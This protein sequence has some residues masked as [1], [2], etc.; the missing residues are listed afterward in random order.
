[1][2]TRSTLHTA[3]LGGVVASAGVLAATIVVAGALTP[4]YRPLVDA[5]SR[6]GSHDE[7]HAALL[8]FGLVLYGTFVLV[9][10]GALGTVVPG[11]E[12]VLAFTIG[13]FGVA[14]IVAGLAP[15][16]PP[17]SIHTLISRIHVD[18]DIVG[19]AMLL[20]AMA[21]VARCARLRVDRRAASFVLVFTTLGVVAFPFTW[22]AAPY[23]LIEIALL[24]IASTWLVTL[25]LTRAPIGRQGASR[26][27]VRLDG[28]DEEAACRRGERALPNDL[29][30]Q[31]AQP[32][33]VSGDREVGNDP[34]NEP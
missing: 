7:P 14:S 26:V 11:R 2:I 34:D 22:G 5:V 32:V 28:F 27:L 8:R 12:R 6:L 1:V 3:R 30:V 31:G 23:G 21:L 9:G 17:G 19:G 10:A 29:L 4:G 20:A 25:A 16:D 13:G 18:A 24:A 15:K 33:A